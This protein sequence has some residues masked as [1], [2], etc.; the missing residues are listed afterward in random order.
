MGVRQILFDY[1]T[2]RQ[3]ETAHF[4]LAPPVCIRLCVVDMPIK[5]SKSD[6][7]HKWTAAD[8]LLL[9]PPETVLRT[10]RATP[11]RLDG[12]FWSSPDNKADMVRNPV[13]HC[14][15]SRPSL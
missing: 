4:F 5:V 10:S 1:C 9:L 2:S 12:Y 3:I 8:R 6:V 14:K 13:H 11:F 7:V 15:F